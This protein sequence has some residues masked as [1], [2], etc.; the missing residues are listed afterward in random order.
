MDL[1]GVA[2]DVVGETGQREALD[3]ADQNGGDADGEQQA[4]VELDVLFAP[5]LV[6]DDRVEG[7]ELDDHRGVSQGLQMLRFHFP[8]ERIGEGAESVLDLSKEAGHENVVKGDGG[9]DAGN[10][11]GE[12][13]DED[14]EVHLPGGPGPVD[15]KVELGVAEEARQR[16]GGEE[17][18]KNAFVGDL[19]QL[20]E[21]HR[22]TDR[23]G[24]GQ[25]SL[26]TELRADQIQHVVEDRRVPEEEYEDDRQG[27]GEAQVNEANHQRKA[28][29]RKRDVIGDDPEGS[30]VG[31][32]PERGT[33]VNAERQSDEKEYVTH[34]ESP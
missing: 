27:Q 11:R 19:G 18:Q 31:E 24:A 25:E 10:D 17:A 33:E 14:R 5:D 2:V 4:K 12:P 7:D 1:P 32:G 15:L 30:G 6:D 16:P 3:D 29:Y 8:E 13:E 28:H 9:V 26:E 20:E 21:F 22:L 34:L 23:D